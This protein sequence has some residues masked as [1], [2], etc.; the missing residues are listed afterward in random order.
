MIRND[1]PYKKKTFKT[2]YQ[3]LYKYKALYNGWKLFNL[4]DFL[5]AFLKQWILLSNDDYP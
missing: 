5:N 1:N 3:L 2:V 4:I